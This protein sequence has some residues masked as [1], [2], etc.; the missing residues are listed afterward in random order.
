MAKGWHGESRRHSRAAKKGWRRRKASVRL[1]R[2]NNGEYVQ[3]V[4]YRGGKVKVLKSFGKNNLENRLRAHQ[5]VA[6]Y[7]TLL[8][9]SKESNPPETEAL[10]VFGQSL[11]VDTV[12]N[13]LRQGGD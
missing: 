2:V 1:I 11:G 4:S 12:R 3:A 9:L 6:D 7:N 10:C 5:F 8:R 13:M